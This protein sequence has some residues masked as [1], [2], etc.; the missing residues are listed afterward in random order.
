[1]EPALLAL[2]VSLFCASLVPFLAGRLLQGGGLAYLGGIS[3][4]GGLDVSTGT[5]T[6]IGVG[7]AIVV[8]AVIGGVAVG[9]QVA[10]RVA[11]A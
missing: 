11:R 1:M 5:L 10:G 9:R 3:W 7:M 4:G 8:F 6:L 2:G